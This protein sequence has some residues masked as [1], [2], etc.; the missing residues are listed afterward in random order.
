MAVAKLQI[1]QSSLQAGENWE[2]KGQ[3]VWIGRCLSTALMNYLSIALEDY[4]DA[5]SASAWLLREGVPALLSRHLDA[6]TRLAADVDAR[7]LPGSTLG[8]NYHH[9]VFAHLAW[10]LA[11]RGQGESYVNIAVRLDVLE[12]ST[13]FWS[14]Y[15]RGVNSL[16]RGQEY[17]MT[18]LRPRGQETHWMAY[19]R[20][21]EA[22]SSSG[23]L[24]DALAEV[25]KSFTLRN[26]DKSIKDDSYEIEGSGGHPVKWDFRRH[27]LLNYIRSKGE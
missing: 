5:G 15:A 22:A 18:E 6:T 17:R 20:L 1:I 10:L 3:L 11:A 26:A 23:W 27:G 14:E 21:L 9:L 19:L 2:R 16:V 4:R 7:K 13:P 8:G 25:D 24:D 12:I